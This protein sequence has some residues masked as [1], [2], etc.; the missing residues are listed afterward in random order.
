MSTSIHVKRQDSLQARP[1]L[2]HLGVDAQVV[3]AHVLAFGVAGQLRQQSSTR[4]WVQRSL[5]CQFMNREQSGAV[6][7]AWFM[8]WAHQA[9][10]FTKGGSLCAWAAH[11]QS[12][13]AAA[14]ESC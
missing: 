6:R 5:A 12:P 3:P 8:L 1:E 13:A 4:V 14:P 11:V 10:L 7:R 2:A 9:C